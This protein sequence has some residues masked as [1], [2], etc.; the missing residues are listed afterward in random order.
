MS[1]PS[2]Y[3]SYVSQEPDNFRYDVWPGERAGL[4]DRWLASFIDQV[5]VG[6]VT[7]FI[8][9]LAGSFSTDGPGAAG[10]QLLALLLP[11]AYYVWFFSESGQTPGKKLLRIKVIVADGGSLGWGRALLRTIG[12]GISALPLGLGY[13][14]AL[15]DGKGQAWHDKIAGTCVVPESFDP[16]T[17]RGHVDMKTVRTQQVAWLLVTGVFSSCILATMLGPIITASVQATSNL[18]KWPDYEYTPADLI[19]LDLSSLGLQ[20]GQAQDVD[21]N[22]ANS[23]GWLLQDA[24]AFSYAAANRQPVVLLSAYKYGERA[25][26]RHDFSGLQAQAQE[27]GVCGWNTYAYFWG[28][29][30]VR[31]RYA[32]AYQE[33]IW[34]DKWII[35]IFGMDGYKLDAEALVAAVHQELAA[36]WAGMPDK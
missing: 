31:C 24:A 22:D 28:G 20:A 27:P 30:I 13:L 9:L 15:W 25:D 19:R 29:G 12:Y 3:S 1:T 4:F 21:I 6:L 7:G 26:A 18:G 5:I 16:S 2:I 32:D 35:E 36:H 10:A 17:L 14:W 33:D 8:V 11:V 23:Q 34:H